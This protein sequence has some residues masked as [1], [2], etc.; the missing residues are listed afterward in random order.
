MHG[1]RHIN[2][3]AFEGDFQIFLQLIVDVLGVTIKIKVHFLP[4]HFHRQLAHGYSCLIE[5]DAV[6]VRVDLLHDLIVKPVT[7][8]HRIRSTIS[9]LM[10]FV[11]EVALFEVAVRPEDF[12]LAN[13]VEDC[14]VLLETFIDWRACE[15]EFPMGTFTQRPDKP[16]LG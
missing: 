6:A 12:V 16:G 14:P 13:E 3:D 2:R 15:C 7:D 9:S 8:D 11:N 1:Q 5:R 4:A 10:F